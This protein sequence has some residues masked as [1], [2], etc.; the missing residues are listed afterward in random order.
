MTRSQSVSNALEN[1]SDEVFRAP[2]AVAPL[3][4]CDCGRLCGHNFVDRFPL[5]L[6]GRHF[7]AGANQKVEVE[8]ELG[9]IANRTVS[10]DDNHIVCDFLQVDFGSADHPVD[11]A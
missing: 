1:V 6:E 9:F 7:L 5:F 11:A 4:V 2:K 8:G 10:W 3:C